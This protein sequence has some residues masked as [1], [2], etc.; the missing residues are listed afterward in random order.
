ML[1]GRLHD[2][3]REK[4][5]PFGGDCLFNMGDFADLLEEFSPCVKRGNINGKN[6]M[7]I[8]INTIVNPII[9]KWSTFDQ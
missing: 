2:G 6:R 7:G 1:K 4:W 5:C 8:L 3:K 9:K